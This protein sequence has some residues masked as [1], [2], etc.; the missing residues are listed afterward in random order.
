MIGLSG[1][2]INSFSVRAADC[3]LEHVLALIRQLMAWRR[4]CYPADRETSANWL[5]L[6]RS[7]CR[8]RRAAAASEFR[9]GL[10]G[11]RSSAAP[12][13]RLSVH[14]QTLHA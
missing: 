14:E 12:R 1:C 2:M 9:R 13:C 3:A 7:Y 10:G 6:C 5:V 4:A 8:G 11:R